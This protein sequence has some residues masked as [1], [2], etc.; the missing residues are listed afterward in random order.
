MFS[1]WLRC[2]SARHSGSRCHKWHSACEVVLQPGTHWFLQDQTDTSLRSTCPCHVAPPWNTARLQPQE[3]LRHD[4]PISRDRLRV[5]QRRST[6]STGLI[7]PLRPPNAAARQ[8]GHETCPHHHLR[9][10]GWRAGRLPPRWGHGP[11]TYP[12]RCKRTIGIASHD[13]SS[14]PFTHDGPSAGRRSPAGGHPHYDR[15]RS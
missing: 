8:C 5:W 11:H 12:V 3:V 10:Y 1:E 2:R 7:Q 4:E 13:W 14:R 15:S 9:P 6:A